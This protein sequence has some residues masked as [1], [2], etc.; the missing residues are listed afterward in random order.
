MRKSKEAMASTRELGSTIT[1]DGNFVDS[2]EL[3]NYCYH[4]WSMMC[5]VMVKLEWRRPPKS[6]LWPHN[7]DECTA[8]TLTCLNLERI[9]RT[10]RILQQQLYKH[11]T[12]HEWILQVM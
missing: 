12:E 9:S 10:C 5:R 8:T 2:S 11:S 7:G 6:K 1:E 4:F 3:N